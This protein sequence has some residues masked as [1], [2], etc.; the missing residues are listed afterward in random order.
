MEVEAL[1]HE[2]F[3]FDPASVDAVLL[4]HAHLDHVGRLPLLIK[5]GFRGRVHCTEATA[6]IARVILLDSARVQK[7]DHAR[8][9]R[10]SRGP[11]WAGPLQGPLYSEALV[12]ETLRHL[13]PK[14]VPH[15]PFRFGSVAVT[16]RPAGHVL[17]S[18]FYEIESPQGRIVFSG[19]LGNR[20]SA[21]QPD[22][23]LPF[24]CDAVV[25]ET[26]YA[27]RTHRSLADT[28]AEFRDVLRR[29]L[30]Q[31][32]AVIIPSFA[33]E[34]TQNVL[35][36]LKRLMDAGEVPSVPVYLDSPMAAELTRLYGDYASEFNPEVALVG[37][38]GADPFHPATLRILTSPD[39]SRALNGQPGPMVIVAGSGM[40][41]GGRV[42]HHLRHRLG[43]PETSLVI[44]GFQAPGS[45]GA[46]LIGGAQ[47]VKLFGEDVPVR[48]SIHTI[49]GFSAHADQDD[50][51]AWLTPTREARVLLVHGELPV[52]EAFQRELVARGRQVDIVRRGQPVT[53]TPD[54]PAWPATF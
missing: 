11:G 24:A 17:G 15:E 43:R 29:S 6:R 21:V 2:P 34:R 1:N 53:M 45:L 37:S 7:E 10:R 27:D 28:V 51:L 26:T 20:N 33:L 13:K 39:Q 30:G 19:N 44:V 50:L 8:A 36:H 12:R 35:Y 18:V 46:A 40:M 32:G 38:S 5:G 14:V 16:A 9:Q 3:P 4:T 54:Q 47:Q 42:R 48:A 31:G 23:A 49:G 22:F 41:N 52:I 25:V